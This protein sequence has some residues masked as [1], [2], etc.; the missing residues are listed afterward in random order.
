MQDFPTPHPPQCVHWGTFSQE[1]VLRWSLG[2]RIKKGL[3]RRQQAF[4]I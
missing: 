4:S 2:E 1:K 3:L